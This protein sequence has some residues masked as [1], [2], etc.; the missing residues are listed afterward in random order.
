MPRGVEAAKKATFG[1]D[2]KRAQYARLVIF[3]YGVQEKIISKDKDVNSVTNAELEKAGKSLVGGN[4]LE[5]PGG[6]ELIQ[7]LSKKGSTT[8]NPLTV[9]YAQEV[10]PFLRRLSL[11]DSFGR[12][13]GERKPRAKKAET[14]KSA[15]KKA[16][17]KKGGRASR[18]SKSAAPAPAPAE[19]VET[20]KAESE[21]DES[22]GVA[23]EA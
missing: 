7:K 2:D 21:A 19:S 23:V 4:L 8:G 14:K 5:G 15:P 1:A 17:G 6:I 3:N 18:S 9:A 16:A 13:Q 12:R 10:R 22:G 11:S 20:P